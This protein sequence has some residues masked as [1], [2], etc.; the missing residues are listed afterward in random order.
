MHGGDF[1]KLRLMCFG[2]SNRHSGSLRSAS[3]TAID[4][5]HAGDVHYVKEVS[6][7]ERGRKTTNRTGELLMGD[8]KLLPPCR[9]LG[10]EREKPL[11]SFLSQYRGTSRRKVKVRTLAHEEGIDN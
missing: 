4:N 7:L 1:R 3:S 8:C 11:M 9:W 5:L 10:V 2:S 6:L